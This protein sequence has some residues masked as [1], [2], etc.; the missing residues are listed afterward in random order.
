MHEHESEKPLHRVICLRT[1]VMQNLKYFIYEH[2]VQCMYYHRSIY[3]HKIHGSTIV[4]TCI[5]YIGVYENKTKRKKKPTTMMHYSNHTSIKQ[6]E[7]WYVSKRAFTGMPVYII[8]MYT[9]CSSITNETKMT[10][11]QWL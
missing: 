4:S 11:K 9:M 2:K 3:K 10:E 1:R 7:M 5:K 6:E 8:H